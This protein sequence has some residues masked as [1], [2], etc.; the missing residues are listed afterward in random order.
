MTLKEE[1]TAQ[2]DRLSDSQLQYLQ[3][4]IQD[5]TQAKNTPSPNI[6]Q[7]LQELDNLELDPNQPS[8]QDLSNLV[9]EVRHDLKTDEQRESEDRHHNSSNGLKREISQP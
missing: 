9:K 3:T 8:L 4:I 1:I 6:D 5:L 7:F 2:L